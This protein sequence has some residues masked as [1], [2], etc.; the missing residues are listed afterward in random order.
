MTTVL[1][2]SHA[3]PAIDLSPVKRAFESIVAAFKS[4]WA[5]RESARQDAEYWALAQTDP[6]VMADIQRAMCVAE[7]LEG[8]YER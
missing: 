8:M 1:T 4:W 5:A 3:A 7:G 6:R 2:H